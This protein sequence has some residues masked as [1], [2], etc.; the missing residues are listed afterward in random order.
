M[1]VVRNAGRR[2][3]DGAQ[4]MVVELTN[5]SSLG[6][7]ETNWL[8]AVLRPNGLLRYFVGVAPQEEFNRYQSAFSNIVTSVQFLD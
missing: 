6:G 8:V 3:V 7:T 5:D 4:A 1:R 2:T